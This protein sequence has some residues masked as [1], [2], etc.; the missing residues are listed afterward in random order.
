MSHNRRGL[1]SCRGRQ[2]CAR[3]E[4]GT[5]NIPLSRLD[6]VLKGCSHTAWTCCE[7]AAHPVPRPLQPQ[8]CHA[9]LHL[10]HHRQRSSRKRRRRTSWGLVPKRRSARRKGHEEKLSMQ[11][12]A[13]R[14][15]ARQRIACGAQGAAQLRL[16]QDASKMRPKDLS[17]R[18]VL[19][20]SCALQRPAS[21]VPRAGGGGPAF[22]QQA[23]KLLLLLGPPPG[24]GAAARLAAGGQAAEASL[25]QTSSAG[26]LG[27]EQVVHLHAIRRRCRVCPGISSLAMPTPRA[28]CG[29]GAHTHTSAHTC[30][31]THTHTG[32][33]QCF[34][35]VPRAMLGQGIQGATA[36]ALKEC[37]K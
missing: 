13:P 4:S 5:L 18:C 7:T 23:A 8:V 35:A 3:P 14:R 32:K 26:L 34:M 36:V 11:H 16:V 25:K 31:R 24:K 6:A 17:T 30:T 33:T 12:R 1:P 20:V 10:S 29:Q 37:E 19:D 28:T 2:G 22:R 15:R 9:V 21:G 27:R